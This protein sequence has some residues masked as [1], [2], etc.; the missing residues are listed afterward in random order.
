MLGSKPP[1]HQGW[2]T[3]PWSARCLELD[4]LKPQLVSGST[5]GVKMDIFQVPEMYV[6]TVY[7]FAGKYTLL[8]VL[9]FGSLSLQ[10]WYSTLASTLNVM[11]P[12]SICAPRRLQVNKSNSLK[13]WKFEG[14]KISD[15]IKTNQIA[16]VEILPKVAWKVPRCN[17]KEGHEISFSKWTSCSPGAVFDR[18]HLAR[19]L[20]AK[21]LGGSGFGEGSDLL[22][23]LRSNFL[24]LL[25]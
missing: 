3:R 6:K 4:G 11:Q 15:L 17:K 19:G 5:R 12:R 8:D 24:Y 13:V 2:N 25:E 7:F 14:L 18:A 23:L 20:G 10:M 22:V 16:D 21:L 1:L 9:F